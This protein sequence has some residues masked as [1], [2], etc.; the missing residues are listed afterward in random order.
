VKDRDELG[1]LAEEQAGLRRVATLVARGALAGEVFAAVAQEVAQVLHLENAVV[2]RY[3]DEGA[4]VTVLAAWGERLAGFLPGSSWPLDGPSVSA[5][6][7]RTSRSTGVEDYT[8]VPGSIAAEARGGGF[9][10]VAGAPIIVDGQVW[11]VIS[12]S[13]PASPL[14]EG[15][16]DRLADFTELVATAIANSQAREELTRLA[17]EQAALRR[18]ATLVAQ[19]A[20][21]AEVFEVVSAEVGRLIPADA[22][23]LSHYETDGTVTALGGGPGAAATCIPGDDSPSR[24]P[25]PDWSS[26]PG[27]PGG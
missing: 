7:F 12:T 13:S 17:E 11:G 3:D 10:T 14:A 21:P 25:C 5:E 16:E 9:M 22:A 8:D 4:T 24:E 26:R 15:L 27:G 2:G 19:G 6:V 18:V 23:A 20:R 1:R